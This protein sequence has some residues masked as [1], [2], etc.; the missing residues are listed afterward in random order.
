MRLHFCSQACFNPT[1][2]GQSKLHFCL[3]IMH[4]A[5]VHDWNEIDI[6]KSSMIP[7]TLKILL[8]IWT[9]LKKLVVFNIQLS[10][11]IIKN[12]F[13]LSV[14]HPESPN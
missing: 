11:A 6:A 5:S 9:P 1:V 7:V 8:F 13:A 3:S 12:L 14:K 10:L 4:L 2:E